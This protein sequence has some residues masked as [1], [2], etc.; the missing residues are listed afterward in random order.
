MAGSGQDRRNGRVE[1][2]GR[3]RRA[4]TNTSTR[5][6]GS[7]TCTSVYP[8]AGQLRA[9]SRWKLEGELAEPVLPGDHEQQQGA[10]HEQVS[11]CSAGG[12]DRRRLRADGAGG[13]VRG[14]RG[15]EREGD[16]QRTA[17][18]R[19]SGTA[20]ARRR[21][22]RRP[23]GTADRPRRSRCGGATAAICCQ[24]ARTTL[25]PTKNPAPA[26]IA[27]EPSRSTRRSR[28]VRRIAARSRAVRRCG[29][30]DHPE[31]AEQERSWS[32]A[33]RGCPPA[34][35]SRASSRTTCSCPSSWNHS[36]SVWRCAGSRASTVTSASAPSSSAERTRGLHHQRGRQRGALLD[37]GCPRGSRAAS[38][39]S[40][41]RHAAW[42]AAR[43]RQRRRSCRSHR[44]RQR[45]RRRSTVTAL[46]RLEPIGRRADGCRDRRRRLAC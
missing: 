25:R 8:R 44:S 6:H 34:T 22:S 43:G 35:C 12:G 38:G 40:G 30:L 24:S 9:R 37:A 14:E 7:W 33:R 18:G 32:R 13:G 3:R 2:H 27:R 28:A 45:D 16:G 21:R 15:D 23:G 17:T 29:A 20:A 39:P 36:Q 26:E 5:S 10:E 19:P 41:G 11:V 42:P 4:S 1:E 31:V 46:V